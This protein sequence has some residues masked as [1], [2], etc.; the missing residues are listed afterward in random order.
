MD[1][2]TGIDRIGIGTAPG[3]RALRRLVP[4]G[5]EVV[6]RRE[7]ARGPLVPRGHL[8]DA[9]A[10]LDPAWPLPAGGAEPAAKCGR[11]WGKATR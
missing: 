1:P 3:P 11:S 5:R 6:G 8:G 9:V 7:T 4:P 2:V 10:A